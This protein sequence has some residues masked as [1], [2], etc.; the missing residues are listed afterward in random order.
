MTAEQS[1][2]LQVLA[3]HINGRPSS[4]PEQ[5]DWV[6][7][8]EYANM[9][10]V[11]GIFFYQCKAFLPPEVGGRMQQLYA[12][13]MFYY[14]NRVALVKKVERAYTEAG[15]P[16]FMVKGLDVAALYPKPAL[17]TMGDT[18]IVIHP[19]DQKA[20]DSCMTQCGITFTNQTK[21]VYEYSKNN[22]EFEVHLDLLNEGMEQEWP[23]DY[24][25]IMWERTSAIEG[26]TKRML[27]WSY[28]YIYLIIHIQKHMLFGGIGFRQFMDLAIVQKNCQLDEEWIMTKLKELNLLEFTKSCMSMCSR[29][30]DL[31]LPMSEP[32]AESFYTSATEKIF[33][34]GVFGFN[35]ES[36]D[37]NY[38][39]SLSE[40]NNGRVKAFIY[41][42]FPTY[43]RLR[44][45]H[46]FTFI[47][48]RP[49]LLPVA[50]I[51]RF[52]YHLKI[53]NAKKMVDVAKGFI[54]SKTKADERK[55]QLDDWGLSGTKGENR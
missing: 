23:G 37:V 46:P 55:K 4:P 43:E 32:V 25:Q 3:D 22:I 53:G 17:R 9:H 2:L 31:N 21:T 29:W 47:D 51:Y 27:D 8:L 35:D 33:E 16:F 28:H 19:E 6:K 12:A 5:V 14:A 45:L 18:D 44:K 1:Y 50:W 11:E 7:L 10:Q 36:N 40:Q 26:T 24:E 39:L 13:S 30:F 49:Y 15:I 20:A 48:G 42:V 52:F 38:F 41:C 54:A 34:N